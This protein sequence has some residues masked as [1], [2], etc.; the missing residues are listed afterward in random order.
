MCIGS[1]SLYGVGGTEGSWVD[2]LKKEIHEI[3][4]GSERI[5]EV[6]EIYNLGIPGAT[7]QDFMDRIEPD[8]KAMRK[9]GRR[10]VV[11]VQLGGNNTKAIDTPD[12]FHTSPEEFEQLVV[13][14]IQKI[15][16]LCDELLWL[17]MNLMDESKVMP[18]IKDNELNTRVYFPNQRKKDFDVIARKICEKNETMYIS[19][20]SEQEK[21]DWVKKYQYVDG[22][23]PNDEG[24]QWMLEQVRPHILKY[25]EN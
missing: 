19:L 3:Q 16:P 4:Y 18:I 11:I 12:N 5:G 1:S 10:M 13:Q 23:H 15:L 20:I 14:M 25:L 7:I 8:L 9:P 21:L 22:I 17:G 6:H 24:Y 2:L